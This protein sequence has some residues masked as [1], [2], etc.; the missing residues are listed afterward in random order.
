MDWINTIKEK[1]NLKEKNNIIIVF[2][3][4][5]LLVNNADLLI[6]ISNCEYEIFNFDEED[7]DLF[8]YNFELKKENEKEIKII[9]RT[10]HSNNFNMIPYDILKNAFQTS[11]ALQG[12]FPNLSPKVL[13]NIDLNIFENLHKENKKLYRILS[14]R[15]TK[16]FLISKVYNINYNNF[17]K[18]NFFQCFINLFYK[19]TIL[20]DILIEYLKVKIK[21]SKSLKEIP[22]NIIENRETFFKYLQDQWLLFLND[23]KNNDNNCQV[24]FEKREILILIDNLFIEGLLFPIELE[25]PNYRDLHHSIKMGIKVDE[26]KTKHNRLKGLIKRLNNMYKDKSINY[27]N[28]KEIAF[29]LSEALLIYYELDEKIDIEIKSEFNNLHINL[30]RHFTEWIKENYDSLIYSS[31]GVGPVLVNQIPQYIGMERRNNSIEKLVLI[32]VDGLSLAQWITMKN[33]LSSERPNWLFN[34]MSCF[35]WIPT[36]T[37]VSRQSIFSGNIPLQFRE[38]INTTSKEKKHW[39]NFWE[40]EN[41]EH[42]KIQYSIKHGKEDIKEFIEELDNNILNVVG[43][44]INVVDEMMHGEQL[45]FIG[46]QNSIKLWIKKNYLIYLIEELLKRNYSIYLTSDHGNICAKG[47]GQISERGLTISRGMRMLVF[48]KEVFIEQLQH[49]NENLIK[50]KN[51]GLPDKYYVILANNNFAFTKK[52]EEI[53]THGGISIEEV[54]VPFIRIYKEEK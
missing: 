6:E 52:G 39:L 21:D 18:V 42:N 17:D 35:A 12:F 24:P 41:I 46:L 38:S 53:I 13:D 32:V 25:I 8:R 50:W 7:T 33:E 36:I 29:L 49:N 20:P 23:K 26:N 51:Y 44:V 43:L 30:E 28:W 45:G 5:K 48:N 22:I 34:E 15:E 16:E 19:K 1:L 31:Y 3:P 10:N 14:D 4:N 54:M 40:N 47:I 37:T 2:D 9:L 27:R 11:I